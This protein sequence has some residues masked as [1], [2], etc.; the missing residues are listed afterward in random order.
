MKKKSFSLV[1]CLLGT[2][3]TACGP[4]AQQESETLGNIVLAYVTADGKALPDPSVVTHINYAFGQVDST[5]RR[6]VISRE[7]RL[8]EV[9]ELK[10]KAPHLKVMLS[11]GGWGSG[12]FSEMA[13]DV[14]HR[15]LFARDCRRVVEQFGLDGIDLDWEYPTSSA[16]GISASPDDTENFTQLMRDIRQAIGPDRLL[17]LASVAGAAYIDFRAIDPY[18]DFVNI[19][20]YDMARPPY[21]HSA[22][23]PSPLSRYSAAQAVQAHQDAGVAPEK[24][25]L[26]V[27]FY[28]HAA[29][30]M[31]DFIRYDSLMARRDYV[32]C[33]DT[34]ACVPY[35]ADSTGR[36]VASYENPESLAAKCAY[37]R[38]QG[39]LG[40]MYWEYNSDDAQGSLREA[41]YRH[42]R[43]QQP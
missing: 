19:M 17:T 33:W 15:R 35:L 38:E 1:A 4:S 34:V 28:G 26:G 7:S 30:P 40:I 39:L 12:R 32:Q 14:T 10:K 29:P 27:P 37:V 25:V 36:L 18:V 22:L 42:M 16:A 43:P 41:V 24:L 13:A 21:H 8:K 23:H 3:L 20:A 5:F 31:S 6:I 9:A 11:I 2:L